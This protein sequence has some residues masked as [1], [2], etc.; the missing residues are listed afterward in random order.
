MS[1]LSHVNE[2]RRRLLVAVISLVI[3]T[4]VSFS[5]SQYLAEFL[6]EPVGGLAGLTSIEVT[7][8]LA[9]FMKISLLS[10]FILALPIILYEV[11]AF[12]MPGLLPGEKRWTWFV[13]P[14]ATLFFAGGVAFAYFVMLPAALPF[15][16]NFMGITTLPRPSNYFGFIINL[17]FW[18]GMSFETPLIAMVLARLG[19]V[20]ARG[21]ARQWRIAVVASSILAA[22]ITPT[23]DPVNMGLLMIPLIALYLLSIVFAAIAGA[24]RGR[25]QK[26]EEDTSS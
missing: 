22:V 4:L 21:L 18:G 7:E 15:M 20:S 24:S 10:G 12:V 17:L 26:Q 16:L 1:F 19:I 2:L 23:L 25:K 11:L 9:A 13:I 8:N 5:F 3:T 6:A 14:S